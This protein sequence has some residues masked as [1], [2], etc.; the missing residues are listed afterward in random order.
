MAVPDT[1]RLNDPFRPDGARMDYALRFLTSGTHYLWVRASGNNDGGQYI[2]AGIGLET[3]TWGIKARTGFGKF[4]WTRLPPFEIT[5]RGDHLLSIWM[6]EDGAMID[7]LIVTKDAAFEPA[8]ET[9]DA[10]GVMTGP[11]PAATPPLAKP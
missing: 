11:G 2:H 5:T 7:R 3:G 4:T 10:A 1:G 6:C 9:K 8:P